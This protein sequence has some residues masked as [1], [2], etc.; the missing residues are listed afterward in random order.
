MQLDFSELEARLAATTPADT[1]RGLF[2]TGVLRLVTLA[3]GEAEAAALARTLPRR[4]YFDFL[5]YPMSDFLRLQWRAAEALAPT[6]G[7]PEQAFWSLGYQAAT[8]FLAAPVGK[9]VMLMVSGEPQALINSLPSAYRSALSFGERTVTWV[10]E[11]RAL[12]HI[13]RDFSVPAYHAGVLTAALEAVGARSPVVTPR[14]L[15]LTEAEFEVSW[16]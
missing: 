7:G 13:Q 2:F 16:A 8:D 11:R 4:K 12:L 10:G 3:R 9:A 5:S 6:L 15:G 1:L 14:P